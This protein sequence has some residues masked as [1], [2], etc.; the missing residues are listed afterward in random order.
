[1]RNIALLFTL[2]SEGLYPS[3]WL[4]PELPGLG[5]MKTD[6]ETLIL[7]LGVSCLGVVCIACCWA[8][9]LFVGQ[10]QFVRSTFGVTGSS[11]SDSDSELESSGKRI[12]FRTMLF[13]N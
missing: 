2:T 5:L 9:V 4:I 13:L 3:R 12:K 8:A 1:M 7:C 6:G 11:V 10:G